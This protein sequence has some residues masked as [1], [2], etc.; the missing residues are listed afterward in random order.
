MSYLYYGATDAYNKLP[1]EILDVGFKVE[2]RNGPAYEMPFPVVISFD[3]PRDRI[4]NAPARD[5]NPTFH[6]IEAL[7]MLAGREDT[8]IPAYYVPTMMNYSDN[9]EIFH[10]AY[11]Y[12]WRKH[13]GYDQLDRAVQR[14]KDYKGDR[15]CVVA[16]WDGNIDLQEGNGCKDLPCNMLI[17]FAVR[18]DRLDMTVFNRSNDV[19]LGMLGANIVHMTILQ[20]YMA[21]RLGIELGSYNV[22]SDNAHVYENL[23]KKVVPH[24]EPGGITKPGVLF[25]SIKT[26]DEEL[27][28]WFFCW[29]NDIPMKGRYWKNNVLH[30]AAVLH[31]AYRVRKTVNTAAGLEFL[32][33]SAERFPIEM[34]PWFTSAKLWYERRIK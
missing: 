27:N 10:A 5:A 1:Q 13:F 32:Q 19:I 24:R 4:I 8:A 34:A 30:A 2:T 20:E 17:K 21:D 15:R 33:G 14:L 6:L 12:R 31:D 9:G 11:G 28:D 3:N 25:N 23:A 22:V 7:W 16:M 26:F 29:D 18:N